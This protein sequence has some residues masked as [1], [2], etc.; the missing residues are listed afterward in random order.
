V[1]NQT[2]P[3]CDIKT[4]NM[5]PCIDVAEDDNCKHCHKCK[6][7][8][9]CM[10]GSCLQNMQHTHKAMTTATKWTRWVWHEMFTATK[11]P[12]WWQISITVLRTERAYMQQS[13]IVTSVPC[14]RLSHNLKMAGHACNPYFILTPNGSP[15]IM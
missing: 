3:N 4:I 5:I 10:T 14:F 7:S 8:R 1:K 2:Q 11:T 9:Q 12:P 6:G 13:D 15:Y